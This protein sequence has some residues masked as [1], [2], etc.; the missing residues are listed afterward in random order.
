MILLE[1]LFLFSGFFVV[2]LLIEKKFRVFCIQYGLL[3]VLNYFLHFM[4]RMRLY[5]SSLPPER[6]EIK[7]L[8]AN[9]LTRR[10]VAKI[11]SS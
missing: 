11:E 5:L 9:V 1:S 6:K 10:E 8:L 3:L 7:K 4:I 2:I